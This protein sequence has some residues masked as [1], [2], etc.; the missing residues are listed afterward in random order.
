[1]LR[2]TMLPAPPVLM[3]TN[4]LWSS[5]LSS[6]ITPLPPVTWIPRE[7]PRIVQRRIARFSRPAAYARRRRGRTAARPAYPKAVA[8]DRDVV[9]LDLDHV[10]GRGRSVQ[11]LP[12]TPGALGGKGRRRSVDESEA[13]MVALGGR[14]RA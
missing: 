14:C 7:K 3:P 9:G 12:Q 11:V 8:V 13:G 6:T 5:R 4:R 2:R 10:T 1:M